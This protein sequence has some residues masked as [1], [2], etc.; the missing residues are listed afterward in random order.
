MATVSLIGRLTDDPKF[1]TLQ[2]G[3]Q[4]VDF[5]VAD[6]HGDNETTFYSVS[7][8]GKSAELINSSCKKGHRLFVSGTLKRRNYTGN[9]GQSGVSLDIVGNE[10]R[11]IEPAPANQSAAAP[12]PAPTGY[13]APAPAAPAAPQQQYDAQGNLWQVINGQWVMIRPAGAPPAPP[14]GY[15]AQPPAGAPPQPPPGGQRPY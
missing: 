14:A 5:D 2:S 15:P 4:V 3:S 9:N 10:F 7:F 12:A 13:P 1:K 6:N 11:F 8:F